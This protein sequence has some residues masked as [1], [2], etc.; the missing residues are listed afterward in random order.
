MPAFTSILLVAL[1][2][3]LPIPAASVLGDGGI[4]IQEVEVESSP[5]DADARRLAEKLR[6]SYRSAPGIRITSSGSITAPSGDVEFIQAQTI[7]SNTGDLKVLSPTRNL[8]FREGLIYA[9]SGYF[10]GYLVRSMYDR[11]PD[12]AIIGL[13]KV[14][15]VDPLPLPV[16]IRVA[17]SIESAFRPY[18]DLIGEDGTVRAES[19]AWPDGAAAQILRFRSADGET[20][21]AVWVDLATGFIRG[22]RGR[23]ATADGVRSTEIAHETV[24]SQR[25][26]KIVVA[27]VN[28][29]VV[30]SFK[31]LLERWR[32]VHLVPP[33]P[34]R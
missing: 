19:T 10:P 27:V 7:L 16:R 5:F 23:V 34:T 9:D 20:D 8:T 11:V 28:R 6:I 12:G 18:L 29:T 25:R 17:A 31:A 15:P 1:C 3:M 30:D 13:E 24:A 2:S 26:P 14:W 21:I 32:A 4:R 33:F 22:L